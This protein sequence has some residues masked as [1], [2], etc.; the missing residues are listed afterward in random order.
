MK[1]RIHVGQLATN[2]I[3]AGIETPQ[4]FRDE[5]VESCPYV[6]LLWWEKAR[7]AYFS[8]DCIARRV[9]VM[10]AGCAVLDALLQRPLV[11]TSARTTR[12]LRTSRHVS[13]SIADEIVTI[14]MRLP[15]WGKARADR[16]L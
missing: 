10:S 15:W 1:Q 5:D 8:L 12:T 6:R 9:A 4:G 16:R 2:D 11:S 3:R 14:V 13:A 7:A